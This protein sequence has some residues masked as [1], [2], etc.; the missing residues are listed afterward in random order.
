MSS[1]RLRSLL[2]KG[3]FELDLY[4]GGEVEFTF[5]EGKGKSFISGI[6]VLTRFPVPPLP[7]RH[8]QAHIY[9][10]LVTWKGP[11]SVLVL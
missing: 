1:F 8:S 7:S 3:G 6:T 9:E 10:W 5:V 2:E 11:I 4:G